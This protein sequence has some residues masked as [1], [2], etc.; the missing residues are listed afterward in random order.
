MKRPAMTQAEL[1]RY[2]QVH[3][4]AVRAFRVQAQVVGGADLRQLAWMRWHMTAAVLEQFTAIPVSVSRVKAF[5]LGDPALL[6]GIPIKVI[7]QA[8]GESAPW[9]L[10]L[11][12]AA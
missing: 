6:F 2:A 11:G 7:E 12:I 5:T 9:G 8:S 3:A 4:L 10:Y 1:D